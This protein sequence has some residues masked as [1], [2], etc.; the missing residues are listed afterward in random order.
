MNVQEYLREHD[1]P[2]EAKHHRATFTA[3]DTAQAMHVSGDHVAKSVLM[4]ADGHYVLAVLPATHH[5]N[6]W[7][8]REALHAHDLKLAEESDLP[9]LFK[10]CELGAIPPFGSQY[11][12]T[13]I[14]DEALAEDDYIVF[15]ANRLDEAVSMKYEDY[16][17]LEHPQVAALSFS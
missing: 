3:R 13:T 2:F 17:R 11:G 6:M 1:V 8:A 15:P 10:D 4:Q 9:N 5:L 16:E 14:V 7:M 12:I